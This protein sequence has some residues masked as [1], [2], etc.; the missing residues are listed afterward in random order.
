MAANKGPNV[1]FCKSNRT[2]CILLVS[3]MGTPWLGLVGLA[4]NNPHVNKP[5]MALVST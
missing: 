1:L 2:T 5:C 4:A 3:V